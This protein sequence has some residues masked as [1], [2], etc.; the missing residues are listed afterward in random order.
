[1]APETATTA[2]IGATVG[3][4]SRGVLWLVADDDYTLAA[5]AAAAAASSG[6]MMVVVD[7]A[8]LRS[9]RDVVT[10]VRSSERPAAAVMLVGGITEE[11]DWQLPIL[12]GAPE[13][14]GGGLV[15]FPGRR[16]VAFYGSPLTPLLGVMGEQDPDA[17]VDR[18]AAV[19]APYGADGLEV[20]PTFELIATV[21]DVRAGSDG[22]YSNEL[23]IDMIRPWIETAGERGLYVLLDL[24]PGRTDFLTQAMR[25]EEFL[26]LPHVGLALD[27]EWRL[28]PDEVH[29]E[30]FGSVGADE[31]NEVSAWLAEIVRSENL[32][33]KMLLVHQ[34]RLSMIPDRE[35]IEKPPELAM[36]IQMDGQGPIEAKYETWNAITAAA[37][38]EGWWWGWKNFYDED[39]PTPTPDQVLGLQPT[40]VYV[41]YQ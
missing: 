20:L 38:G 15:L 17:T 27:P 3:D 8:D 9:D 7:G 31:V 22:N 37:E 2:R 39:S 13:L 29:L 33:Q 24:Q 28:G 14:P 16:M 21:A 18:L 30:Q 6:G 11:A 26:R 10:A 32:P 40:V 19:A 41:S 25:Y 35:R 34:F 5:V 4:G 12:L 36:V 23:E 1:V